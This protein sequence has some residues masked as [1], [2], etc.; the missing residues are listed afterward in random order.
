MPSMIGTLTSGGPSR[1]F[2]GTM[3]RTTGLRVGDRR[4]FVALFVERCGGLTPRNGLTRLFTARRLGSG[5]GAHDASTRMRGMLHRRIDTT[6]SGSFGILHAHVSHF[7]MTR[8]GVR[9][10]RNGVNHVVI[11][12]PNVGRPRH[13]EGLLRNSTG[14]RF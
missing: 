6:I 9:A 5:M 13:I 7:N 10:L 2:G 11:R 4:S 3:T 14:L 8:P 1:T 12:L